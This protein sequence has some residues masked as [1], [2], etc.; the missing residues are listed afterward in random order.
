VKDCSNCPRKPRAGTEYERTPCA[1]CHAWEPENDKRAALR[2][3]PPDFFE[4]Q[5]KAYNWDF[6][7]DQTDD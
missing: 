6:E 7:Y 4:R 1:R 3:M 2:T 5:A